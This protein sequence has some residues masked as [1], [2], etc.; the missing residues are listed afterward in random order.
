VVEVYK[1]E[2]QANAVTAETYKTM[3]DASFIATQAQKIA[4]DEQIEIFKAKIAGYQASLQAYD[5]NVKAYA[6]QASA[7][8]DIARAQAVN[9]DSSVKAYGI[10]VS[11]AVENVKAQVAIADTVL[12]AEKT[13]ILAQ[14]EVA[15]AQADIVA[16]IASI[17]SRAAEVGAQVYGAM[18][19]SAMHI[20][21]AN[22]SLQSST[23]DNLSTSQSVH[24]GVNT[25]VDLSGALA[26]TDIPNVP[27]V[28]ASFPVYITPG[29][30][31]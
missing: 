8:A 30:M 4:A 27:P 18:A 7:I 17:G 25:N 10:E 12:N 15:K 29:T 14:V 23:A 9:Y 19:S 2:V 20:I 31:A 1:S 16:Q 6:A 22:A 5:T 11:A 13:N 28:A 21:S 3:T 24:W 26:A